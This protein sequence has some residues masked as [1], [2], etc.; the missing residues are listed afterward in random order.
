MI[1]SLPYHLRLGSRTRD[2]FDP[3]D[4]VVVHSEWTLVEPQPLR[5]QLLNLG[6]GRQGEGPNEFR[7]LSLQLDWLGL[8]SRTYVVK[9][10]DFCLK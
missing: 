1:V 2:R 9:G 4:A 5:D 8:R 3:L 7:T 6:L 10:D